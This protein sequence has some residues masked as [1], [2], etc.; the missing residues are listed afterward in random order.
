MR[1]DLIRA[2]GI[3]NKLKPLIKPVYDT[4][5]RLEPPYFNL[6]SF[7]I[8]TAGDFEALNGKIKITSDGNCDMSLMCRFNIMLNVAYNYIKHEP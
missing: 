4:F 2:N 1:F 3:I 6:F 8:V 7:H 5:L